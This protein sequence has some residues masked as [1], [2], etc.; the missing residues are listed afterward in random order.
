MVA[1]CVL[2]YLDYQSYEG[3]NPPKTPSIEVP[4]AQ[5]KTLP[6][7]GGPAAPK[8]EPKPDDA[9]KDATINIPPPNTLPALRPET[10]VGEPINTA[11]PIQPVQAPLPQTPQTAPVVDIPVVPLP[12]NNSPPADANSAAPALPG[13]SP[14]AQP[15]IPNAD[16]DILEAPPAPQTR[17]APPE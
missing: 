2:L 16:P 9:K 14:Q 17:L 5:L 13:A 10:V 6:G 4:G 8:P 11:Q 15:T 1:G 12:L 7:T 3:K